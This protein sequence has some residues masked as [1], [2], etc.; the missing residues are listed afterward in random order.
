MQKTFLL[1]L[2][3]ALLL[4]SAA[5]SFAPAAAQAQQPSHTTT[6]QAQPSSHAA[7]ARAQHPSH[8]PATRRPAAPPPFWLSYA[9]ARTKAAGTGGMFLIRKGSSLAKD[10]ILGGKMVMDSLR[11]L[12][13]AG[14]YLAPSDTE[15]AAALGNAVFAYILDD[16]TPLYS[17]S[18]L[19]EPTAETYLDGLRAAIE[20][21]NGVHN[22]RLLEAER[23]LGDK[24]PA[25]LEDIIAERNRE[26]LPAD[27]LLDL[28][29]DGLPKDSV[30]SYRVL[31]FLALQAPVL[32]STAN[33]VLRQ[34]GDLF[35]IVWKSLTM[36]ERIHINNEVIAK[37]RAKA[38]KD[39]DQEEATLAATFAA[40]TNNNPTAKIRAFQGVMLEFYYGVADTNHFLDFAKTYYDRFL[41]PFNADSLRRQD[42]IFHRAEDLSVARFV[43]TQLEVGARRMATMTADSALL[44]QAG[45]WADRAVALYPSREA[46]ETQERLRARR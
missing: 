36:A 38:V 32:N 1:I 26:G 45:A 22:L 9:D 5:L 16:G 6:A 31:R 41:M 29:V 3:F 30:G 37:T 2:F 14:V 25:N 13:A 17:Y 43:G 19:R 24:D 35:N 11:L 27:S 18:A 40:N 23:V 21:K 4:A 12:C 33:Q 10:K 39:Q 7:T 8:A 46:L 44:R 15:G 20:R 42:S 28:Y 34:D